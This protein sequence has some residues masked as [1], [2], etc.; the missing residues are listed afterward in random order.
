MPGDRAKS[1]SLSSSSEHGDTL[2][3][4]AR[5]SDDELVSMLRDPARNAEGA[6]LLFQFYGAFCLRIASRWTPVRGLERQ[7]A[8]DVLARFVVREMYPVTESFQEG[9]PLESF[10]YECIR[11]E[12]L[13]HAR[14]I[15]RS[16]ER[17]TSPGEAST[18]EGLAHLPSSEILVLDRLLKQEEHEVVR[19]CLGELSDQD[20]Q[21]LTLIYVEELQCQ[22]AARFLGVAN[23]TVTY[24][25][26]R[27]MLRL[28]ELLEAAGVK[29]VSHVRSE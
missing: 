3:L 7:I 5:V 23:S 18:S 29:G 4:V 25:L 1:R 9:R 14:R 24:R 2:A 20:R 11:N 10:L 12:C 22:E 8:E 27:A 26:N 15:R 21:I 19:A 28:K 6:E 16:R 13:D 17:E